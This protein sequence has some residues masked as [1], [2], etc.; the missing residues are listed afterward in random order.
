MKRFRDLVRCL[1]NASSRNTK[2]YNRNEYISG[3]LFRIGDIVNCTEGVAEIISL[4]T[5]YV[6]LVKDGRKFKSWISDISLI[7]SNADSEP[8]VLNK[9]A[10]TFKGY[11]ATNIPR[12][13][14]EQIQGIEDIDDPL[15]ILNC[16]IS[17][18][19]IFGMTEESI[20]TNFDKYVMDMSNVKRYFARFNLTSAK[21]QMY[22]DIMLE[23]SIVK[24]VKFKTDKDKLMPILA[25]I[26]NITESEI[27]LDAA[28]NSVLSM[29]GFDRDIAY[30]LICRAMDSGLSCSRFKELEGIY[31]IT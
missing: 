31:G 29:T 6:T 16:I 14:S 23:H 19:S 17:C 18:D 26:F 12:E 15:A 13:V 20:L 1:E 24:N 4:G 9:N 25:S 8:C 21:L 11:T 7:E 2:S 27:M 22:D 5:N 28:V 10:I 3:R 30:S